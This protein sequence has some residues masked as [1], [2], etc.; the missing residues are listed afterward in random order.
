ML[1]RSQSLFLLGV[2]ILS[3]LL[4]TGAFTKFIVEGGELVLKH[5]GLYDVEGLKMELATWPF[6]LF[7]FC[8]RKK[9]SINGFD[10]LTYLLGGFLGIILEF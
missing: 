3:V 1:Q 4:F 8:Y 7:H 5:S 2:F 10:V 9:C 6:T